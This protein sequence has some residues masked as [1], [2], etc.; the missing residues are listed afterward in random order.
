ME[1]GQ[2]GVENENW[3]RNIQLGRLTLC[4][5]SYFHISRHITKRYVSASLVT[6]YVHSFATSP[7]NHTCCQLHNY[8]REV[9]LYLAP[10]VEIGWFEQP[11]VPTL[12]V[13]LKSPFNFLKSSFYVKVGVVLHLCLLTQKNYKLQTLTL[14]WT[15]LL[16]IRLHK[17]P[18]T[19]SISLLVRSALWDII[20][21]LFLQFAVA[22]DTNKLDSLTSFCRFQK[23]LSDSSIAP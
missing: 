13:S 21:N 6:K 4:Q 3:T 8:L 12:F 19:S 23:Y 15:V 5:L 18:F 20:A 16:C 7:K 11:S 1:H 2:F 17:M 10:L 22:Y 9:I 14:S